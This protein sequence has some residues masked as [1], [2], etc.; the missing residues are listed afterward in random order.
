LV[1]S[2]FKIKGEK[3]ELPLVIHCERV[4]RICS[5]V[6]LIFAPGMM[7]GLFNMDTRATELLLTRFVGAALASFGL[8][9][10]FAKDSTDEG[11]Q[12]NMGMVGLA[13]SVLA[14]IVTLIGVAGGMIRENG[15][16]AIVVEVLFAA[17]YAF[18]LFLQPRMK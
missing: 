3:N 4:R 13:G 7:L 12:R 10:W 14:L 16:I 11:V 15:W 5:G 8:L 9:L 1:V 2:K 17:G 18:L 6:A